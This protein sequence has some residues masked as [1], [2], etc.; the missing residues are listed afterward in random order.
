MRKA[1]IRISLSDL[2]SPVRS[3]IEF[4]RMRSSV[5]QNVILPILT[6]NFRS[7]SF[8]SCYRQIFIFTQKYEQKAVNSIKKMIEQYIDDLNFENIQ[9]I[10]DICLYPFR[11]YPEF[12]M[13]TRN[14]YKVLYKR[15]LE[16]DISP[17]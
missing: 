7:L 8:E 17:I 12:E 15:I 14:L 5:E 2:P 6:Q 10:F 3:E 16:K 13:Q 9:I 1:K 11:H 4:E